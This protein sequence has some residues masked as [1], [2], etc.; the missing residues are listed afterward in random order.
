[1]K[2]D[3]NVNL[4]AGLNPAIEQKL[5]QALT[6]LNQLATTQQQEIITLDKFSQDM[7]QEATDEKTVEDSIVALLVQYHQQVINAAGDPAAQ[8]AVLAA[9]QANKAALAA[10]LLANTGP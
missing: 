1:M 8:A 10:A 6:L 3:V 2:L 9:F 4:I 5:D 7:L